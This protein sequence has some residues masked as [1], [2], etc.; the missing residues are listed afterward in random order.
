M[1]GCCFRFVGTFI[2]RKERL[3]D[4]GHNTR[5]TNLYVKNFG[6]DVMDDDLRDMFIEHGNIMSAVVM[7]DRNTN[8][9]LCYGFVSFDDHG[10]AAEVSVGGL[11]SEV[12]AVCMHVWFHR[13]WSKCMLKLSMATPFMFRGHRRRRSVSK[14]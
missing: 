6:E 13:L 5:F 7:K 1:C 4:M 14:S 12:T 10:S 9:S 2:S 3:K 11:G 8:K